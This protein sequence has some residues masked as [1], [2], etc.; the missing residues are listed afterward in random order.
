MRAARPYL[1]TLLK[2]T[3]WGDEQ[4][5]RGNP[6]IT[7]SLLH[8]RQLKILPVFIKRSKQKP[9][10]IVAKVSH[11]KPTNKATALAMAFVIHQKNNF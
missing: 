8:A 1:V 10:R 11:C 7:F 4:S 2:L 9:K 6:A 3:D 5:A